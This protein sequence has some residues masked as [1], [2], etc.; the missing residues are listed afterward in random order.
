MS[1]ADDPQVPVTSPTAPPGPTAPA[2]GQGRRRSRRAAAPR[3]DATTVAALVVA[4]LAVLLALLA[5]A[6]AGSPTAG[7]APDET[8]LTRSTVV[9]APGGSPVRVA[10][11]SGASGEVEA[12]SG[13]RTAT[14]GVGPDELGEVRLGDDAVVLT[15]RDEVAPGLVAGRFASPAASVECAAPAFDHWFTGVGAGATHRSVLRLVNPDE[16][17]AVVDVTVY[18]R[19]GVVPANRLRGVSL[20]G[21]EVRSIRLAE[22]VPRT[23]ELAVR[24][25]V[26]RGRVGVGMLDT[27]RS[28]GDDRSGDDGLAAQGSPGRSNVLLGV[29]GASGARTLVLANPGSSQGRATISLV[30]RASTFSPSGL[31]PVV[32][33]PQSVVTV[34]VAG[35]LRSAGRGDEQ[36]LGL[37]VSST[38]RATASLSS[39]VDGDLA[40]VVP[41]SRLDGPGAAVLPGGEQQLVLGDAAARGSV[42]VSV[43]GA[44]G[45]ELAQERVEVAPGRAA[46]LDLPARARLVVVTP[47]R[48]AVAAVVTVLGKGTDGGATVVRV[49]EP[50]TTGLVPQ[51][52]PGRP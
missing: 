51:V 8:A 39:Y 40:T 6:G 52:A 10:T 22:E 36:A 29:L 7:G 4:V 31:E 25:R 19:D 15:A 41:A 42:T 23:D 9:C 21:G 28:L 24:V 16:G 34:P 47:S 44:D 45:R 11:T 37:S 18:G 43:R 3:L 17:G 46:T 13:D 48:T 49:R 33:P 5:D 50:V 2:D 30:T 12:R 1:D 27:T 20:T 14:A 35:V 38:V 32:L 26:T